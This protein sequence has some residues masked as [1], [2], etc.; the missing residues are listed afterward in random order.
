VNMA[1]R[2]GNIHSR[3]ERLEARAPAP[4]SPAERSKRVGDFLDRLAAWRRAGS[5]DTEE[6][7]ELQALSEAFRK[8]HFQEAASGAE[9]G[10]GEPY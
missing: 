5:P 1:R 4:A 3:L 7:R 2:R 10:G 8:R 6:G 9:G